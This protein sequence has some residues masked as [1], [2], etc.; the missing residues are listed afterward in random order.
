MTKM[1]IRTRGGE[2]D[3]ELDDSPLSDEIWLSLPFETSLNMW[4]DE[5]YFEMPVHTKVKGEIKTLDVGDI[6]FWPEARAI[7]LFFGPT[8]L[9]SENGK[10]IS[11]YPVKKFGRLIGE[12]SALERS[13][14]G[15][16]I[17]L[18]K[19]F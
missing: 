13:G 5:I 17:L 14:D 7:C 9:S 16:K 15:T 2:F 10:P 12:F 19:A 3:A 8:P 6:A 4:G 1:R 11:A 18:E